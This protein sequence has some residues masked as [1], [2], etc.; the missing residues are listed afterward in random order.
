[1]ELEEAE[2][3]GELLVINFETLHRTDLVQLDRTK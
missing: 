3:Q 1:M 2:G